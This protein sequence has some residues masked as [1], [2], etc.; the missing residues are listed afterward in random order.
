MREVS[1]HQ[2]QWRTQVPQR[3][4]VEKDHSPSLNT[5]AL[6]EE[7]LYECSFGFIIFQGKKTI[8]IPQWIISHLVIS[9]LFNT[10]RKYVINT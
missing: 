1:G 8:L 3:L 10:W 4:H 9:V 6:Y 5:H 7:Y 2:A